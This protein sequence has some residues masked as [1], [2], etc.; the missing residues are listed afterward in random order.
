[1]TTDPKE[2]DRVLEIYH[3]LGLHKSLLGKLSEHYQVPVSAL[4]DL[5]LAK[6]LSLIHLMTD[7]SKPGGEPAL[8]D[9]LRY[10]QAQAAQMLD[11]MGTLVSQIDAAVKQS[12]FL[13]DEAARVIAHYKE[14]LVQAPAA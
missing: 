8:Q 1:M 3:S 9:V 13:S 14:Q 7:Y 11:R 10:Q 4:V 6:Q 2:R 12:R 5:L